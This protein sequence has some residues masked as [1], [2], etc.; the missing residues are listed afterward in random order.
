MAIGQLTGSSESLYQNWNK[1]LYPMPGTFLGS[2]K[3]DA[4]GWAFN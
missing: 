2:S 1:N 3:L 4:E